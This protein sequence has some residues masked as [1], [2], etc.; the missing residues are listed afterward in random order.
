MDVIVEIELSSTGSCARSG[1][2][3]TSSPAPGD[4]G[5]GGDSHT[6]GILG[7]VFLVNGTAQRFFE[8]NRRRYRFRL[9]DARSV[10]LYQF[11]LTNPDT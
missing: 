8:V 2:R 6:D 7:N 10:A 9:L 1:R 3:L 4:V 5:P 11:F